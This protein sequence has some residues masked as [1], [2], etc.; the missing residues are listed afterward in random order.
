MP[1]PYWDPAPVHAGSVYLN[2][3]WLL[4][5]AAGLLHHV[6]FLRQTSV[7]G[8]NT[9][10]ASAVHF[11]GLSSALGGGF[12]F[13]KLT[14]H[15]L[16]V[17]VAATFGLIAFAL[18]AA[19]RRLNSREAA[20]FITSAAR[21]IPL[22]AAVMRLG[23]VAEHAHRG[24][25]SDHWLAVD[26]P[27]GARWDLALL[28]AGFFL[29]L[30]VA[31]QTRLVRAPWHAPALLLSYG[32]FRLAIGPLQNEF[33]SAP[34]PPAGLVFCAAGTLMAYGAWRMKERLPL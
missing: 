16:S 13:A 33:V 5:S 3:T 4:W 7:S 17:A 30:A 1:I 20:G 25:F 15:G 34:I 27:D 6:L 19:L 8:F 10:S 18:F 11:L 31:M 32:L 26:Y 28:E 12:L 2:W 9:R 14:G 22:P 24:A 29:I 21:T 23:C